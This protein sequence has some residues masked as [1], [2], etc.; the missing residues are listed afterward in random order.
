LSSGDSE[1]ERLL[2]VRDLVVEYPGVTVVDGVTLE[3]A[4]GESVGVVGESGSGKTTLALSIL[5]L[6][7]GSAR[8]VKGSIQLRGQELLGL[9]ENR[10]QAVRGAQVSL[11]FQEPGIA[12]HPQLRVGDQIVEVLRAHRSWSLGRCREEAEALLAQVGLPEP[13]RLAR[14]YPHELS[15]GQQQRVTIAQAIACRP[16]LLVADEPTS[17]LDSTTRAEILALLRDLKQRFS[18]ALLLVTHDFGTL[19]AL[20]DRVLV[21]H[22]GRVV[23]EGPLARVCRDPQHPYTRALLR[24]VPRPRAPGE[25]RELPVAKEAPHAG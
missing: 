25:P 7:P 2:Q 12:L 21:M 22:A 19:G 4:R 23:E 16:A 9:P 14:A 20:A 13:S 8:V 5:G 18:L 15:G 1:S 11:V 6:L 24:A 10:L 17:A 3:V